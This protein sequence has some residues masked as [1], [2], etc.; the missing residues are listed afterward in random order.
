MPLPI[1][2]HSRGSRSSLALWRPF[3][4]IA[5]V[6]VL[7]GV[8]GGIALSRF[9]PGIGSQISR[10]LLHNALSAG[11]PSVGSATPTPDATPSDTAATFQLFNQTTTSYQQ[12]S[13]DITANMRLIVSKMK[14]NAPVVERGIQQGWMVVAPGNVVTHF[15]YSA[16]P[17]AIGNT[18]LYAHDNTTFRHLDSLAVSDTIMVQTPN[19][20]LQYRVRE[21]RIIAPTDLSV[22]DPTATSVLTLL[23]CYP[24]GV[25]TSRLVVIADLAK[26]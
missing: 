10:F 11:R 9:A 2:R 7:M 20:A 15:V 14:V 13:T 5:L 3:V 1:N 23:T 24:F 26:S 17:G 16:Y 12:Q 19:G 21:I 25:D 22:L 8:G 18:I 4:A 6:A